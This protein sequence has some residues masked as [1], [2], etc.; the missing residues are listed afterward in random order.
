MAAVVVDC[1]VTAAWMLEDEANAACDALL[2]R[3]RADAAVVPPI[4][5]YEIANVLTVG[6]RM[7][8]IPP[9]GGSA[10]MAEL[11]SLPIE[12]DGAID[13][14]IAMAIIA[15]AAAHRLSAYDAAYL[16]LALR[17]GLP[18]ATLDRDLAATARKAG[19]VVLPEAQASSP[20]PPQNA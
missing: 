7:G 17:T 20:P 12:V 2:E 8:R 4:W 16:E 10:R 14:M 9:R 1:S 6:E 13:T 3:V 5:L 19:V 18:L 15:L 11:L